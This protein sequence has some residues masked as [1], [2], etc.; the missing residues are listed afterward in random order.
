MKEEVT[1]EE[2]KQMGKA[3]VGEEINSSNLLSLFC[4]FVWRVSKPSETNASIPLLGLQ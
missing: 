3:G 2:N 4:A 1:C